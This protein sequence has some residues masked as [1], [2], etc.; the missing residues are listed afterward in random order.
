MRIQSFMTTP[1]N[2]LNLLTPPQLG[3]MID[4]VTQKD[5]NKNLPHNHKYPLFVPQLS[6]PYQV[7]LI[8]C[9]LEPDQVEPKSLC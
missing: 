9:P 1:F 7:L 3:A 6:R 8:F 5:G 2:G 4:L